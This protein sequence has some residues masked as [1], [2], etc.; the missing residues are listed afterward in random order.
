MLAKPIIDILAGVS[1]MTEA[2]SLVE[3]ICRSGYT[4]SAEFN[5]TL[6]DRK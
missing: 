4:T 6:S 5:E 3:P 2:E 1:S